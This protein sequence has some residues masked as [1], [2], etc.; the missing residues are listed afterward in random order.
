MADHNSVFGENGA[1]RNAEAFEPWQKTVPS[2]EPAEI[3][4]IDNFAAR[5]FLVWIICGPLNPLAIVAAILFGAS[6]QSFAAAAFF[7]SVPSMLGLTIA[8]PRLGRRAWRRGELT[9]FFM[10]WALVTIGLYTLSIALAFGIDWPGGVVGVLS[11]LPALL[12]G[13]PSFL[14]ILM[15][16]YMVGFI[17]ALAS[18]TLASLTA[19]KFLFE[20]IDNAR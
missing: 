19:Q 15:F 10:Y 6:L 5:K 16:A 7:L 12:S 11:S 18:A 1:V 20:P 3:K 8:L 4:P 9:T 2:A 13:I 17:P 14:L